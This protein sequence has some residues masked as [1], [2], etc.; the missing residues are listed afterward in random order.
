MSAWQGYFGAIPA[1][2]GC[3]GDLI[4]RPVQ[5]APAAEEK[6]RISFVRSLSDLA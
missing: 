3:V 1:R 5:R 6:F 4:K 2:I